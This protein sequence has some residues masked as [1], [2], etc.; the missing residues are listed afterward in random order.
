MNIKIVIFIT[1]IILSSSIINIK[2]PEDQIGL[3]NISDNPLICAVIDTGVDIYHQLILNNLWE[4]EDEIINGEDDDGNGFIDD[5]NGWNFQ[6]NNNI[7]N[8]DSYSSHG[9]HVTGIILNWEIEIRLMI[10]KAFDEEGKST[11]EILSDS[12][13]YAVENGANIISISATMDTMGVAVSQSI[14]RAKMNDVLM[15]AAAGNTGRGVLY[16]AKHSEVISVGSISKNFTLSQFSNFG[17]DLDLVAFGEKINSTVR[18]NKGY[19]SYLKIEADLLDHV[20]IPNSD[21]VNSSYRVFDNPH[22]DDYQQGLVLYPEPMKDPN[23]NHIVDEYKSKNSSGIIFYGDGSYVLKMDFND[24][25]SAYQIHSKDYNRIINQ[26]TI[27][28]IT[29]PGDYGFL[30]G[31]SMATPWVVGYTIKMIEQMNIDGHEISLNEIKS[32]LLFGVVDLGSDGKDIF[33]GYGFP[34]AENYYLKI[35]DNIKP[36]IELSE[37]NIL[38]YENYKVLEVIIELKDDYGL[39]E[40]SYSINDEK[41]INVDDLKPMINFRKLE[42]SKLVSNSEHQ[43]ELVISL[44]DVN[45]NS[46]T[47]KFLWS[48]NS[49]NAES[50]TEVSSDGVS[51]IHE[52]RNQ[53]F[54]YLLIVYVICYSIRKT[55]LTI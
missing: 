26:G 32:N 38:E 28:M 1:A 7:I 5:I 13:D 16:P 31:T 40:C 44:I 3:E 48:D 45:N 55:K 51:S 36:I 20:V 9:T 41:L 24:N 23:I 49:S 46:I 33:Y 22:L 12:I 4:N 14:T 50:K 39:L 54:N 10:L 17:E 37:M 52:S 53:N 29:I 25:F 11:Q 18:H 8:D 15:I 47:E 35:S 21:F 30:S 34:S 42:I 2:I 6:N 27:S 43:I 19:Q